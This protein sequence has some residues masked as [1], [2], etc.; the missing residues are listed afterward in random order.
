MPE[1]FIFVERSIS[2]IFVCVLDC[3]PR[4]LQGVWYKW[5]YS[6]FLVLVTLRSPFRWSATDYLAL[7]DFLKY[8]VP[9]QIMTFFDFYGTLKCLFHW[10]ATDS[11]T[12]ADFQEFFGVNADN[13]ICEI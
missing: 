4:R 12:I 1:N 6:L 7:V 11:G 3:H 8:L 2:L 9:M 10:S 13:D 5:I